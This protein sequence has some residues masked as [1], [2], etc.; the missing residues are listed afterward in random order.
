LIKIS[1]SLILAIGST[2]LGLQ[3]FEAPA[4]AVTA[5]AAGELSRLKIELAESKSAGTPGESESL[6]TAMKEWIG[7]VKTLQEK[8]QELPERG[9]PEIRHLKDL[10]WFD[11]V[12]DYDL[13]AGDELR[14]SMSDLRRAA[15]EHVA[16]HFLDAL[17]KYLTANGE[18]LPAE[19]S[20]LRPFFDTP[21][22]TVTAPL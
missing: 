9:I 5:D 12:R 1:V 20:Q 17:D 18:E 13:N 4:A 7:R 16:Q 15:M 11:A 21:S 14:D 19:I 10:D 6:Q 8:F 22:A 3:S 2:D